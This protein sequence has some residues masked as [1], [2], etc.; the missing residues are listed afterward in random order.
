MVKRNEK[1]IESI[2]KWQK[3]VKAILTRTFAKLNTL[4]SEKN[5][6]SGRYRRKRKLVFVSEDSVEKHFGWELRPCAAIRY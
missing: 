1:N 6:R 4:C 5:T 3:N 2:L